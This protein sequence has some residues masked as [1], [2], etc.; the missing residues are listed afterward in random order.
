V[1]VKVIVSE[2]LEVCDD[3]NPKVRVLRSKYGLDVQNQS[4][5]LDTWLVYNNLTSY[6]GIGPN[7]FE[8]LGIHRNRKTFDKVCLKCIFT[9][10]QFDVRMSHYSDA[11]MPEGPWE[12]LTN[13]MEVLAWVSR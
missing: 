3:P 12:V 8:V 7:V 10:V 2:H 5:K 11:I 6:V 13:E 4:T 9:G 1:G